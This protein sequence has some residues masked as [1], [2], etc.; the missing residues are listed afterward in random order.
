MARLE[1]TL[2][3]RERE[4][5][6]LAE[7]ILEV[8]QERDALLEKL[9]AV[10]QVTGEP[11][12]SKGAPPGLL[13]SDSGC[14]EVS[15]SNCF[16]DPWT[17]LHSSRKRSFANLA[18]PVLRPTVGLGDVLGCSTGFVCA[19]SVNAENAGSSRSMLL[20]D[21]VSLNWLGDAGNDGAAPRSVLQAR[22]VSSP[23]I[24]RL[25]FDLDRHRAQAALLSADQ[26]GALQ[27]QS[28]GSLAV[29]AAGKATTIHCCV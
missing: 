7:N 6:Q 3:A 18:L 15:M 12:H 19:G 29:A 4:L 14:C 23:L 13:I 21:H 27:P 26:A 17:P 11:R 16:S 24:R 20:D 2:A 8:C 10:E 1:D 25:G 28:F 9:R 5:G 22:P